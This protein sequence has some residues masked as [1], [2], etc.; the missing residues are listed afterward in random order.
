M[1]LACNVFLRSKTLVAV[2]LGGLIVGDLPSHAQQSPA[3]LIDFLA[4]RSDRP[5][6]AF[7]EQGSFSCGGFNADLAAAKSLL[8]FGADAD[9][10]LEKEIALIEDG[11]WNRGA[12][13]LLLVYANLTKQSGYNRLIRMK[14]NSKLAV[15]QNQLDDALAVSLS[16]T[17]YVSSSETLGRQYRCRPEEPRDALNQLI[18]AWLRNDREW[19][20]GSL[21]PQAVE[22]FR[23]AIGSQT[24]SQFRSSLL[25]HG[26]D[27]AAIGY[28]FRDDQ[29]ASSPYLTLSEHKSPLTSARAATPM[30]LISDFRTRAGT[31]CGDYQL[32][33]VKDRLGSNQRHNQYLVDNADLVELLTLVSRCAIT[34]E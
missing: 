18:L 27:S 31:S 20:E 30:T 16:L 22:A 3:E 15:S 11:V 25:P 6:K 14:R 28:R 7:V 33:F 12:G 17:D 23:S 9:S 8:K 1:I 10:Q 24:W 29:W 26:A 21:S 34:P 32:T 4:Y 2:V 13:W 19:L 5:D